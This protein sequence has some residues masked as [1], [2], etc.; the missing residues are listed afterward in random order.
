LDNCARQRAAQRG[1][2]DGELGRAQRHGR[3]DGEGKEKRPGPWW[4]PRAVSSIPSETEAHRYYFFLR[5]VFFFVF[6]AAGFFFAVFLF[7]AAAIA[8]LRL[9]CNV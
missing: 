4:G 9:K 2:D 3:V 6:L 7:F 8:S 1:G 5:V